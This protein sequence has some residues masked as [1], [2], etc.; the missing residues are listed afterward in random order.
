[1]FEL[2]SSHIP[3]LFEFSGREARRALWLWVALVVGAGMA[4]LT[5][6]NLAFLV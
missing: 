4:A 3:A 1:M 2:I 5:L 6:T